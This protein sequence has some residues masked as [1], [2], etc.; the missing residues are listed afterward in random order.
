MLS[1]VTG[2]VKILQSTTTPDL[3][4][5]L[6]T[7][8]ATALD[9][10]L[11]GVNAPNQYAFDPHG[12]M[13][14]VLKWSAWKGSGDHEPGQW[15][16]LEAYRQALEAQRERHEFQAGKLDYYQLK[17]YNPN[18]PVQNWIR[19]EAGHTT[20][21]TFCVAGIVCHFFDS[22]NPSITY[23]FAPTYPQINDLLFKYIREHRQANDLPGRTRS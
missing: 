2:G 18:E 13:E 3:R 22:F 17:Y 6:L 21:K 4:R 23:A 16:I 14:N 11:A 7:K 9:P 12:Y 15:E 20:G 8:L 5:D 19:V 10:S 1:A